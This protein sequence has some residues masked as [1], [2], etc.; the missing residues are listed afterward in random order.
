MLSGNPLFD[1]FGNTPTNGDVELNGPTTYAGGTIAI[2]GVVR[3]DGNASVSA[4]TTVNAAGVFDMDGSNT[5]SP[6]SWTIKK[7]LTVNADYI[8]VISLQPNINPN[9]VVESTISVANA[10]SSLG[11]S[12]SGSIAVNLSNFQNWKMAGTLNL[13]GSTI[14]PQT[15]QVPTM[16]SGSQ[17][18]VIGTMNVQDRVAISAVTELSGTVNINSSSAL[19]L[20]NSSTIL[21]SAHIQGGGQLI[22]NAANTL[23]VQ[24]GGIINAATI[25][26]GQLE[27]NYPGLTGDATFS[28]FQQSVTG[29]VNIDL[30]GTTSDLH[31][32]LVA[33]TLQLG[34]TLAVEL[35][36]GFAPVAG[37]S[38]D[39]LDWG[40]VSG[41]FFSFELPQVFGL[42]WDT[43]QLYVNGRIAVVAAPP[44][45]GDYNQNGVVDA[46]DYVVWRKQA[47]AA[48]N[49][50]NDP[51]GGTVGTLQYNTWR[52][53]FGRTSSGMGNGYESY[54]VPE[55]SLSLVAG[56]VLGC[57][58]FFGRCST[59]RARAVRDNHIGPV[60]SSE[61]RKRIVL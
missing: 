7:A 9:N 3:Q 38:F 41:A 37:Q 25:N 14:F 46:A 35:I 26:N 12:D 49:L 4:V 10:G 47:G 19:F 40:T 56:F 44:L 45:N 30:A 31:D 28:S 53:N 60:H 48:S 42:A 58:P 54:T 55:P 2:N 17:M 18:N 21:A 34:G 15:N 61:D 51:H 27:I 5:T 36:N 16:V 6:A 1:T 24:D 8:E 59:A 23:I 57:V 22:N 13:D 39:I 43:S 29:R 33:I 20:N 52:T 32:E 11:N 50:P